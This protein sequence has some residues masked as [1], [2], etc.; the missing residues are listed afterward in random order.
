[1]PLFSPYLK[2]V[3][4]VTTQKS[5]S[6]VSNPPKDSELDAAFG[7]PSDLGPGFIGILDDNDSGTTCYLCWTTGTDEEWFYVSGTKATDAVPITGNPIG[8][9]LAL[10]YNL[11]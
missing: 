5:T 6:D 9:L 10:T 7:S 2:Q 1:M 8:L 4:G 11:D 3:P